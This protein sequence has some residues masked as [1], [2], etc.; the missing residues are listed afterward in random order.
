MTYENNTKSGLT[1]ADAG[2]VTIVEYFKLFGW[3]SVVSIFDGGKAV[4][5]F[6]ST[7]ANGS[8]IVS[9]S[10]GVCERVK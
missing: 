8:P 9:Q 4:L 6:H 7:D 10:Y 2:V 1:F 3:M 5:S